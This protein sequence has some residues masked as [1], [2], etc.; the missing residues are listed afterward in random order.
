VRPPALRDGPR[1]GPVA[2]GYLGDGVTGGS[3]SRANAAEFALELAVSRQY[4]GKAPVVSDQRFSSVAQ[5]SPVQIAP[6]VYRLRIGVGITSTN[7]YFVRSGSSWVLIDTA[8]PKRGVEIRSAAEPI[9]GAGSRPATILLTHLHATHAG[10]AH[11]LATEWGLPVHVTP[12][13]AL[14]HR[15]TPPVMRRSSEPLTGVLISGDA[16]L[17]V[18]LNSPAEPSRH[19]QQ[20]SGP[21]RFSTCDP[22]Q[23]AESVERLARLEPHVFAAGHGIAMIGDAVA[24]A[25][26][27]FAVEA[28]Q[29]TPA[30]RSET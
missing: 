6:G 28:R 14:R 7:I 11:E 13:S 19:R 24:P 25:L 4:I 8:G 21:P 23:A 17:T 16:V 3:L 22:H 2:A 10:S 30:R 12:G 20:V 26:L 29:L 9:F 1:T 18:N 27:S 5:S 15:G